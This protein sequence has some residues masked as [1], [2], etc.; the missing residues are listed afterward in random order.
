MKPIRFVASISLLCMAVSSGQAPQKQPMRD[1]AT[2]EQLVQ[3]LRGATSPLH[4]YKPVEGTDPS[5]ILPQ[6]IIGRS[7]I[8]CFDGL[9]TLVPKE[10]IIFIPPQ[11]QDRVGMKE[12][13]RLVTWAD[14]FAANHGW[15][16][17]QEI[18]LDQAA[19]RVPLDEKVTERVTKGNSLVVAT[20]LG[21]PVSKLA[22][23]LPP[24][25]AEP[26][27]SIR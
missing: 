9:A 20:C 4:G 26:Q 2:H 22:P 13:A 17:T 21:G 3:K 11:Y 7:D 5:K 16:T 27:K 6:D 25:D 23:K 15:I 10:A 1:A 14:F 12:G 24:V 19:G 18:T 8:L